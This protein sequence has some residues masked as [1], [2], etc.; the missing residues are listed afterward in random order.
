MKKK[1]II[2]SLILGVITIFVFNNK[3]YS[4]KDI[5]KN[6]EKN[7]LYD[8]ASAQFLYDYSDKKVIEEISDFIAIIRVDSIDGVSN[9]NAKVNENCYPF[10][11]GKA[12]VLKNLKGNIAQ[13]SISFARSGGILEFDKWIDGEDNPDKILQLINTDDT[14]NILVQSKFEGDIDIELGKI[15][16]VY[17]M[18]NED[19]NEDIDF[20]INGVQ[21]GLRE[22]D[23]QNSNYR[24]TRSTTE[25]IKVKNND[26]GKWESINE[27]L[28]LY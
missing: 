8:K 19:F 3:L 7:I 17:M 2:S 5:D 10:T 23:L 11:Y 21:Y 18:K 27:V 15:Y 28:S 20:I 13:D 14:K 12:T 22:V 9:I 26:T 25:N 6:N 1:L 16:L 24:K 4:T